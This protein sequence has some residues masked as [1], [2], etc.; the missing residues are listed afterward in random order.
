MQYQFPKPNLPMVI[1][2]A[3]ALDIDILSLTLAGDVYDMT[4]AQPFPADQ[5]EH[6][7]LTEVA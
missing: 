2:H 7:G 3:N 5:L 1:D 6:L 4:T